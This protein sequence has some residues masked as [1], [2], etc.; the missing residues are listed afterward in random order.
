MISMKNSTSLTV[1]WSPP[2]LWPGHRIE[3]YD[4]L[5]VRQGIDRDIT[6][7]RESGNYTSEVVAV[8]MD[9]QNLSKIL[10]CSELMVCILATTAYP[11]PVLKI[12]VRDFPHCKSIQ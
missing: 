7:H 8:T 6:F 9:V 11:S 3:H 4:I 2:F 12:C 10:M 5:F 1:S